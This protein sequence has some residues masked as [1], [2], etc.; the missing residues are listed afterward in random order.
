MPDT[1]SLSSA[2][3]TSLKS[4]Q[5]VAALQARTQERLSTG[6]KFNS[7]TDNPRAVAVSRSLSNRASDLQ[8]VKNSIGQGVS[9]LKATQNG[10]DTIDGLLKQAKGVAQQLENTSD[11]AQQAVL[12]D[13]LSTLSQ[14]IDFVA[15]DASLGGT[16]LIS[17]T[18]DNLNI[19]LNDSGSSSIEI[20]GQAVDSASLGVTNSVASIDAAIQTVRSVGQSIGLNAA[21]L[22]I[23]EDFTDNLVNELEAGAQKLV[24]TDLNEEAAV[25]ISASTRGA[26]ASAATGIA[27]QSER[28][29][30]QLF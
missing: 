17:S 2:T 26:L 7:F 6:N 30:L 9:S 1:I 22:S 24:E 21:T 20:Q 4:S 11:P 23:R 25:S 8:G 19:N 18:P 27:A 14:Q 10:L 16:S 12:N 15:Q 13:Q 3:Q 28:S 5:N 29:I